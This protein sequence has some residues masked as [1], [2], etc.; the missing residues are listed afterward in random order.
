MARFLT[1]CGITLHS[2]IST[3]GLSRR[4]MQMYFIPYQISIEGICQIFFSYP[5][6]KSCVSVHH[7][8]HPSSTYVET[9]SCMQEVVK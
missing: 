9:V 3:L 6:C 5:R 2:I 1:Y 8:D 7:P 4:S